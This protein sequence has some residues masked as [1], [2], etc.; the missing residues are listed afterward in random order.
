[1]GVG[2]GLIYGLLG[3][4]ETGVAF[5]IGAMV[6]NFGLRLYPIEVLWQSILSWVGRETPQR[7]L[8]WSPIF[9]HDLIYL[10]L[11]FLHRH[12]VATAAHDPE[13]AGRAIASC[14][15]IPGQA[16]AGSRALAELQSLELSTL[17]EARRFGEIVSL[18]GR[19]LPGK[20]SD[21]P[22]LRALA[23]TARYLQ[24]A[25]EAAS[26]HTG[27][28]HL[29]AAEKLLKAL[30]NQLLQSDEAIA[31]FLP[32]TLISFRSVLQAMQADLRELASRQIP[33][34]FVTGNP[35]RQDMPWGTALF[36]GRE[37]TIA[38]VEGLLAIRD[39]SASLALIG[40]RRC[41]KSSLLNM[42]KTML[43]DT[44]VVLFDLQDNPADSPAAFYR[45]LAEQAT[46]QAR[47]ERRLQLPAW[48]EG[49]PIEALKTWL[50]T[51]EQFDGIPRILIC[52]DEFERLE[53]LFPGQGRD[54]LQ[55]MGL[56]RA[57]I[58]HRRR[59]RL[60][61]AGA[62]PFDELD[63]L[64]HDHFINLREIRIGYLP[65]PVAAGLL[66]RPIPEFPIGAIDAP[67]ADEVF[68]RTGGQPFLTQCYGWH[69]VNR[70]NLAERNAAG[71]DD[72][73]A[74]EPTVLEEATYY[75][76]NLWSDTPPDCR[77]V[78]EAVAQGETADGTPEA[79]RWLQ[80]RL[81]LDTDGRLL[82]PVFGQWIRERR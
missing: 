62:A 12:I 35:L 69:L 36:R 56:L 11:P 24:A 67:V 70:L 64:W 46:R 58:Q 47:D 39:A 1:M 3:S 48:P 28:Q 34:P 38:Q 40:P 65:A 32:N 45:A 17:A 14:K 29:D 21:S 51:L 68:R 72:V 30:E 59:V 41:G 80:R 27:L 6:G 20:D 33:N 49:Q 71:I 61:V 81:M 4:G 78:L 22:L 23:D 13:L 15:S 52:I 8:T 37:D 42:L 7:T 5:G 79:R 54:L 66:T 9:F 19:W 53:Q 77:R 10:P 50:D 82:V 76:N 26:P 25:R 31:R 2:V 43:P 18:E 75:F 74:V 73:A 16:G 55:F 57:T 44:L 63:G 60:L